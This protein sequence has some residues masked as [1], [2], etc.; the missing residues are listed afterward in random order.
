[1]TSTCDGETV[2][3]GGGFPFSAILARVIAMPAP[4][5][6]TK[7]RTRIASAMLLVEHS[8]DLEQWAVDSLF[9]EDGLGERSPL[10]AQELHIGAFKEAARLPR[11]HEHSHY[12]RDGRIHRT[13]QL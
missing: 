11:Q 12:C 10:N 1:V 7:P 9:V 4:N 2:N 13:D 6:C 8:G 3:S 5:F